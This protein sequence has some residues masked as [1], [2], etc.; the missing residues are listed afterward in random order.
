MRW[1]KELQYYGFIVMTSPGHLGVEGR[2][3]APHWRLTELGTRNRDGVD[4]P[5]RDFQ[6]WNGTRF[7][8]KQNPDAEIRN[9][10]D[11]EIRNASAPG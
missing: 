2:G 5:T 4:I 7:R 11:A 10:L 1:F 9:T 3:K 8:Q 6:R